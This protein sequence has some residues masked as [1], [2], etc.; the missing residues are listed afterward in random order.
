MTSLADTERNLWDGS[1]LIKTGLEDWRKYLEEYGVTEDRFLRK[2]AE[3]TKEGMC[4]DPR[5]EAVW[6]LIYEINL[7]AYHS[8]N[9]ALLERTYRTMALMTYDLAEDPR[10]M[11]EMSMQYRLIQL[12]NASFYRTKYSKVE[13]V[14]ACD[15]CFSGNRIFDISVARALIPV[16]CKQCRNRMD[17]DHPF[18]LC[19]CV[20]RPIP[21]QSSP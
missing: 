4:P 2:L 20:W 9:N 14:P 3:L 15:D 8:K 5:Q 13:L 10:S 6:R 17:K 18:G 16:P 1:S 12:D 11:V 7:Q 19:E 21:D